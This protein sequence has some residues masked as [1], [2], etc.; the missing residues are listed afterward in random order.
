MTI[1][2]PQPAPSADAIIAAL[3]RRL[4]NDVVLFKDELRAAKAC[5]ITWR[6]EPGALALSASRPPKLPAARA[7][8]VPQTPSQMEGC[9]P[10]SR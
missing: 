3:L 6:E 4:G 9:K 8:L 1:A 7:S 5:S 10:P 2:I